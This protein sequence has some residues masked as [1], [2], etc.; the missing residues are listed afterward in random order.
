[1]RQV[2]VTL[3]VAM[4][5]KV[6]LDDVDEPRYGY[7]LMR[8]TG[9]ASGKLYPILARVQAAGWL[10]AEYECIDATEVGRPARRW[11]KLTGDGVIAA[12]HALSELERQL[13]SARSSAW[14]RKLQPGGGHA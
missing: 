1:M 13:W 7:D 2:R 3:A 11:Y 8:V 14:S 10:R 5:L 9:F 6:F 12:Q 4:V